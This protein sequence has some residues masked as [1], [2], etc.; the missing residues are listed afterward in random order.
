MDCEIIFFYSKCI[1]K[2][3][4]LEFCSVGTLMLKVMEGHPYPPGLRPRLSSFRTLLHLYEALIIKL[5]NRV[6]HLSSLRFFQRRYEKICRANC[7]RN[8]CLHHH[9][10][11]K[12]DLSCNILYEDVLCQVNPKEDKI[13]HLSVKTIM[14]NMEKKCFDLH[15]EIS[16]FLSDYQFILPIEFSYFQGLQ[17]ALTQTIKNLF[18]YSLECPLFWAIKLK[19]DIR[20]PCLFP[21]SQSYIC[22]KNAVKIIGWIKLSLFK[23]DFNSEM[24]VDKYGVILSIPTSTKYNP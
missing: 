14:E 13:E 12:E 11:L 7:L 23:K 6:E 4:P 22:C 15:Q 1:Y 24:E 20:A 9:H 10:K 5:E 19:I 3:N 21:V 8:L 18:V 16:T 17:I 2:S